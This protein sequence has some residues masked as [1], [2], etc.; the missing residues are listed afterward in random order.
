MY[1]TN[2]LDPIPVYRGGIKDVL[3]TIRMSVDALKE[4]DNL[5]LFPENPSKAFGEVKNIQLRARR[6]FLPVLPK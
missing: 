4:E 3:M 1:V 6:S 5:L 2:S